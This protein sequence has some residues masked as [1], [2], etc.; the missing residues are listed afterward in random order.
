MPTV[1]VYSRYNLPPS[2]SVPLESGSIVDKD[3]AI[4]TDINY[5]VNRYRSTNGAS[6]LPFNS[7]RPIFGDYSKSYTYAD[8]FAMKDS[9][10]NLYDELSSSQ[11][12]QFTDFNDFLVKV[13]SAD[14]E[15]LSGF[16]ASKLVTHSDALAGADGALAPSE[17][18]GRVNDQ[19]S[20][21]VAGSVASSS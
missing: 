17:T 16:F 15:T 9:M 20:L 10:Q 6:G 14:D 8:V 19:S 1:K 7:N 3:S 18:P 4:F 21:P 11:R 13:G 12:E 5:I 2:V